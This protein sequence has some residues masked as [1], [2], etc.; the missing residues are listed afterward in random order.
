[1]GI[2]ESRCKANTFEK[3]FEFSQYLVAFLLTLP[4][5]VKLWKG[6]I[7]FFPVNEQMYPRTGQLMAFQAERSSSLYIVTCQF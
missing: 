2:E 4:D 5:P 6:N 3:L 7:F 1:M